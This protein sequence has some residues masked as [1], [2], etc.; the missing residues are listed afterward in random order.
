[1]DFSRYIGPR[2]RDNARSLV[3][4]IVDLAFSVAPRLARVGR[5]WARGVVDEVRNTGVAAFATKRVEVSLFLG[6]GAVFLAVAAVA[7]TRNAPRLF[8]GLDGAYMMVL[9]KQQWVWGPSGPG[10][11][12]DF[13]QGL[14]SVFFPLNMPFIPGYALSLA[15]GGGAI[16]PVIAYLVFAFEVFATTYLLGRAAGFSAA[17]AATAAWTFCLLVFPIAGHGAIYPILA[18]APQLATAMACAVLIV[19]LAWR[20]GR[21]GTLESVLSIAG[22]GLITAYAAIA[23]TAAVVLLAPMVATL[24]LSGIAFARSRSEVLWKLAGAAAVLGGL[25]ASG[26][27]SF[28]LGVFE[29]SAA[30]GLGDQMI[31]TRTDWPYVSAVFQYPAFGIASPLLVWLGLAGAAAWAALGRG[32]ARAAAFGT[33]VVAVLVFAAGVVTV[34]RDVWHGPSP[35]YFEMYL[36]PVYAVFAAALGRALAVAAGRDLGRAV[37]VGVASRCR[38]VAA[39]RIAHPALVVPAVAALVALPVV[40][41]APSQ[42]RNYT[43]P[44]R[45]N[46]V[47]DVL[48]EEIGLRPGKP[49]RGRVATLTGRAFTGSA[50]WFDLHTAD[51]A[52]IRSLGNDHRGVGLW[53]HDIPTLFVYNALIS[54]PFFAVTRRF[55][56]RP[57][58]RQMRNVMTLR[59]IDLR[60]LRALGVRFIIT[61]APA[62]DAGRLRLTLPAGDRFPLH[63]YEL[64]GANFG[65]FSPTHGVVAPD[66]RGMLDALARDE[67]DLERAV[68][69]E[70]PLPFGLVAASAATITPVVGGLDIKASSAGNSAL[71]LPLEFSNCLKITPSTADGAMAPRLFRANLLQ[72]GV[73]FERRLDATIRY[74]TGP[75]EG[76]N[77]RLEDQRDMKRLRIEDALD[78]LATAPVKSPQ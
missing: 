44:P 3:R 72:T 33:L 77:C 11:V 18:L 70:S 60:I 37:R 53:Y 27:I 50:S 43:Y 42:S 45:T 28:A 14:G 73:L 40:F 10:F 59:R 25:A 35:I 46:P 76:A 36:W 2:I 65:Q 63:L 66:A 67:L 7:F 51:Y 30:N 56:E 52:L 32:P 29:Y 24:G 17:A 69:V 9:A 47:V 75:F 74:F 78:A 57:G 21:A 5:L 16:T 19:V 64:E 6:N 38:L 39:A 23:L 49:F 8:N 34:T 54:P 22:A 31:N 26:F 58:D 4:A 13:M 20:I 55:L 12:G 41:S 48:S 1:M 61:D 62:D 15:V 68:V 71:L